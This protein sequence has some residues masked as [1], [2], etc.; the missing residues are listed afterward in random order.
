MTIDQDCL[1]FN[2][3]VWYDEGEIVGNR[4]IFSIRQQTPDLYNWLVIVDTTLDETVTQA[5][6]SPSFEAAKDIV[7]QSIYS[8]LHGAF[9][10]KQRVD[11][12]GWYTDINDK[13][14]CINC[15]TLYEFNGDLWKQSCSCKE[16]K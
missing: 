4:V 1:D 12:L 8:I 5:G 14:R 6:T 7:T 11:N 9:S 10:S 3:I 13:V 16:N 2:P 15:N